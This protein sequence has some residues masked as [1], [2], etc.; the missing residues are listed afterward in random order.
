MTEFEKY[1]DWLSTNWD[2][3]ESDKREAIVLPAKDAPAQF[4]F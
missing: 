4:K 2:L 3:F 1:L